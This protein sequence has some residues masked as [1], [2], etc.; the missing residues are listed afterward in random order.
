MHA[1]ILAPCNDCN[2]ATR[3]DI[4]HTVARGASHKYEMIQC[5]GCSAVSLKETR[6][7]ED[8]NQVET[9]YPC[10]ITPSSRQFPR[11]IGLISVL[12]SVDGEKFDELFFET[13]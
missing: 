8:N 6:E 13:Y 1:T 7:G 3:H 4:V 10:R 2:R 5:R 12:Y 9:Y 11:W